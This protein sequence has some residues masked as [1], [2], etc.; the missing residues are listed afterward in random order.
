MTPDLRSILDSM[1]RQ[2]PLIFGHRG[3]S[4]YAPMNTIPA[5]ELAAEQ[6]ADGVELDV[7]LT[8]DGHVVV[9]HD[10]SVRA[11]TDGQGYVKEM[12]LEQI[13]ALDAGAWFNAAFAGVRIPTLDEVF[14]AVGQRLL[15]NVEIKS[16]SVNPDGTEQAVAAVIR[17]HNMQER[18]IVSSFNPLSLIRFRA[19]MPEVVIGYL[20]APEIPTWPVDTLNKLT[21]EAAHPYHDTV[22]SDFMDMARSRGTLVNTW[23]V[24]DPEMAVYLDSI[25]IDGIICDNPDIIRNAV[26]R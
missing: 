5:F 17:R 1:Y 16:F 19:V 10:D 6:G 7:H 15:V 3:A 26:G 25:G 22:D 13:K 14:E 23:T 9:I 24:N 21:Y 8:R 2:R 20:Y 12:T 4:A 18:V 11:T